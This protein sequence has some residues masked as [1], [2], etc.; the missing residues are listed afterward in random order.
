MTA[1][2]LMYSI[3]GEE[4]VESEPSV[5][6][7]EAT[8]TGDANS[9]EES[10]LISG[11]QSNELANPF[12]I[13]GGSRC[14]NFLVSGKLFRLITKATGLWNLRK[15]Q[16]VLPCIIFVLL[17][18][19]SVLAEIL[20]SSICGP[21]VDRC[22]TPTKRVTNVTHD[23]TKVAIFTQSYLAT[24]T[25]SDTVTYILLIYTLWRVQQQLP[26]LSLA[27]AQAKVTTR[28][29][30]LINA[31]LIICSLAIIIAS[32]FRISVVEHSKLEFYS[33]Y[34]L[35]VSIVYLTAFTC[36]CVFAVLACALGSLTD[37]CFQ[38]IC[39]L[40]EGNVNDVTAIHQT[41]C[42]KLSTV[43]QALRPWFLAH[44]ILSGANCLVLFA[45]DSTHF[46]LLSRQLSR[47]PASF[48]AVAFALNFAIFLIP[49]VYASRVTWKCKD[50]LFKITSMSSGDWSEGHPFRERII[51]NEFIFYAE[52]SKCGFR[53]GKM[54]FGSSGTW[55]SVFL[56]LLGLGVR[57]IEYIK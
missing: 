56:G 51:V 20:I 25:F 50:L 22:V 28:E 27:S 30:L 48:M 32:A 23:R 38:E 55:I 21:F 54:T 14:S 41:L 44:W 8:S 6:Q 24:F 16:F 43:S 2:R 7:N 18:I 26:S 19:L 5:Q 33:M 37:T 17:N 11:Q 47:A 46:S 52:R 40:R 15:K 39:K 13:K 9:D 10:E 45:F 1:S 42:L 57:L 49:C 12:C 36:C 4:N 53:I 3:N 34:G 29:W 35:G 31:I